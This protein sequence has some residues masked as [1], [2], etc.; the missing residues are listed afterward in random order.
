MQVVFL[1]AYI[2]HSN[3]HFFF[4][5]SS[6]ILFAALIMIIY[7][8]FF[9]LPPPPPLHFLSIFPITCYA[10][11]KLIQKIETSQSPRQQ[12]PNPEKNAKGRS[13]IEN[14]MRA[15]NRSNSFRLT[16]NVVYIRKRCGRGSSGIRRTQEGAGKTIE[17]FSAV[18]LGSAK[19]LGTVEWILS[20]RIAV[21]QFCSGLNPMC[22]IVTR[23][24]KKAN[25]KAL[26]KMSAILLLKRHNVLLRFF[27]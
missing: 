13:K 20:Y 1:A 22:E 23:L 12:G 7:Q 17:S 5:S 8:L 19:P 24:K 9:F 21:I 25:N 4:C 18:F 3:D 14:V 15:A 26:V 6:L 11:S 10:N 27:C 16:P 2:V